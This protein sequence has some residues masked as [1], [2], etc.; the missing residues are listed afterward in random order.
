MRGLQRPYVERTVEGDIGLRHTL[1]FLLDHVDKARLAAETGVSLHEV[2][3]W[4]AAVH[5]DPGRL[6]HAHAEHAVDTALTCAGIALAVARHAGRV[7]ETFTPEGRLRLQD[8]KDLATV[9]RVIGSGGPFGAD[10]DAARLLAGAVRQPGETAL[11]PRAPSLYKDERYLLWALGLLAEREP[12][13]AFAL[14]ERHLKPVAAP[15]SLP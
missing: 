10:C 13:A 2:E 3:A 7:E 14:M 12:D 6:P 1:P 9:G 4:T 5:Q 15:G 11:K 8:G